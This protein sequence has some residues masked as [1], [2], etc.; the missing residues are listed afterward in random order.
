MLAVTEIPLILPKGKELHVASGS[1]MH[2]ALMEIAGAESAAVFHSK[3][4]RPYSQALYW[5]RRRGQWIWKI[6]VLNDEAYERL[7]VPLKKRQSVYLKNRKFAVQFESFSDGISLTYEQLMTSGLGRGT[8]GR[9]KSLTFLTP[10]SFK[11]GGSYIL[12]PSSRL[13]FQSAL[14]R[15]NAFSD[16]EIW[17]EPDL[18]DILGYYSEIKSY[19]LQSRPYYLE[20]H[21]AK[22][23][24]GVIQYT[25]HGNELVCRLQNILLDF[26]FFAGL[27]IKTALGM[28][29]VQVH[30]EEDRT[31]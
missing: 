12:F 21:Y 25:F 8:H 6:A 18:A 19:R 3:G 20:K 28:G 17:P 5:H 15:W 24:D 9:S 29:A 14:M 1:V 16:A 7:I 4:P 22:G 11:S 13:V 26:A 10:A 23:F 2:G 27:G 31:P 30:D